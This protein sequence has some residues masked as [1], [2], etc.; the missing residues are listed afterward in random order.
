MK[1]IFTA[2]YSLLHSLSVLFPSLETTIVYICVDLSKTLP[3]H[4]IYTDT[5]VKKIPMNGTVLCNLFHSNICK[6]C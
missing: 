3:R 4:A 6:F 5:N 2:H 1:A